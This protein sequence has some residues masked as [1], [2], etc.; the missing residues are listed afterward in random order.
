MQPLTAFDAGW[1]HTETENMPMHIGSLAV[2][3]QPAVSMDEVVETLRARIAASAPEVALF[4]RKLDAMSLRMG[5]PVWTDEHEPDLDYH[6]RRLVLAAPG[7]MAALNRAAVELHKQLLDRSKPLWQITVIEGLQEGGFAVY[8]KMHHCAVDGGAVT[9]VLD[10]IYGDGPVQAPVRPVVAPKAA[11]GGAAGLMWSSW[12]NMME[13]PLK[14]MGAM[15]EIMKGGMEMMK[16]GMPSRDSLPARAPKTPFNRA[17]GRDRSLGL[18]SIP[19]ADIKAFGKS[20]GA[21]IND[22]VLAFCS[23][24]LRRYLDE[25]GILPAEPL[26][27]GLPVSLREDGEDDGKNQVTMMTTVLATNVADRAALLPAI[28]KSVAVSK[29]QLGRMRPFARVMMDMPSMAMPFMNAATRMFESSGMLDRMPGMLNLWISNVPGARKAYRC[30]GVDAIH[31]FPLSIPMHG[32]ALNITVTSYV[33]SMEFAIVA[34]TQAAP[35]AQHMADLL[36]EEFAALV[37]AGGAGA[38]R[39]AK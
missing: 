14:M 33:D 36:A 34:G 26:V 9:G 32:I 5:N 2:F 29:D 31:N 18:V 17:L 28:Q 16:G 20:R 24:A 11:G 8:F 23:S 22:V 27:A 35:D 30:G 21:T 19:F 12:M 37:A 4:H 39:K 15:P 25:K 3:P 6:V 7:G 1:L 10:R 38:T 13:M